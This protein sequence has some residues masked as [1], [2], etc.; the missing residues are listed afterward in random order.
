MISKPANL[1]VCLATFLLSIGSIASASTMNPPG[2][3]AA[4]KKAAAYGTLPLQF[5]V[6][7]GQADPRVKMLAHGLGYNIL[8]Q[9]TAAAF[10]LH[11]TAK[12]HETSREAVGMAFAG[13]SQSATL[14]AE[15]QLP[16][17][18]NYLNG[19]DRS[20]WQTGVLRHRTPAGVR[21]GG[22][23]RGRCFG[24]PSGDFRCETGA[25]RERRTGAR[26]RR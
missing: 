2:Q 23:C 1:I 19:S 9:P 25:Q 8:L 15:Q 14:T 20:K 18:V 12:G 11:K 17:Y 10:E 3:P 13:A 21:H 16:G 26:C 4:P 22:R 5:E 6:N 7:Q 24:D